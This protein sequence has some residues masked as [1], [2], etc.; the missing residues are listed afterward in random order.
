MR[1]ELQGLDECILATIGDLTSTPLDVVRAHAIDGARKLFPA[2]TWHDA[3]CASRGWN[4][5][6]YGISP[7]WR[8]V[9]NA[10]EKLD[11]SGEVW[12]ALNTASMRGASYYVLSNGMPAHYLGCRARRL[13]EVG[14]GA[15][16][17]VRGNGKKREGHIVPWENGRAYDSNVSIPAGETLQEIRA[18]YRDLGFKLNRISIVTGKK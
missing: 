12:I 8:G 1:G 3:V 18:R 4:K 11:P 13:P 14:R 15:I 7:Y 2:L 10:C 6:V 17:I 9:Q 16:V 5:T